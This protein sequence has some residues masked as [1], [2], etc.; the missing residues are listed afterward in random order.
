[1]SD[2]HQICPVQ[3]R[4]YPVNQDYEQQKSRSG[5]KTMNLGANKLTTSK[6]DTIEQLDATYSLGITP[7]VKANLNK[8]KLEQ[9]Q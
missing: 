1:M 2:R 7:R 5:T 6:Q 9:E 4:I 8:N 3:D